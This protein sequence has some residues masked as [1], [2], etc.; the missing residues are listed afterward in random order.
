M[1]IDPSAGRLALVAFACLLALHG[2]AAQAKDK[3]TTAETTTA[4]ANTLTGRIWQLSEDGH[5]LSVSKKGTKK[6]AG[7]I[8]EVHLTDQTKI[9]YV[10]INNVDNQKLRAGYKVI[11]HLDPEA[12][13]TANLVEVS[14]KSKKKKAKD[15][16]ATAEMP[17]KDSE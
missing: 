14:L 13:D 15:K 17:A 1:R 16:D 2:A 11:V 5:T 10:D 7:Q 12:K 4:K 3:K 9:E 6:K 8:V